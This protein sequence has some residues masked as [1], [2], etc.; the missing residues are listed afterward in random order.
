MI[1]FRFHM[2]SLAAVLIALSVGIVLG[3]GPLND[4]IGATI[5]SEVN[6]LRADK[7]E[8]R[9]QLTRE[10]R[11]GEARESFERQVLPGVLAGELEGARVAVVRLPESEDSA[12]RDLEETLEDA[13]ATV[14]PAV[15]VNAAWTAPGEEADAARAEALREALRA[16]GRPDSAQITLDSILGTVLG[17]RT[18]DV[19]PAPGAAQRAAAF[20]QLAD[21]GLVSDD[22][23][24]GDPSDLI[25]V[26]GGPIQGEPQDDPADADPEA[27][28]TARGWVELAQALDVRS[29]GVVLLAGDADAASGDVSPTT[30]ARSD[31]GLS[32]GLSTVD[33]PGT[34][35]GEAATVLAL[36]EQRDGDAGHYGVGADAGSAIP[37]AP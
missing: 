34:A 3:A 27:E 15:S 8:L 6:R 2:V 29:S 37:V 26:L 14:G 22:G 35:L 16:L 18:V 36:V 20:E 5:T 13:G 19:S 9:R 32:E 21:A 17:G 28:D 33:A 30:L 25:V 1:D 31:S 4:N 7:E 24:L 11:A 23:E 12:A 10:E